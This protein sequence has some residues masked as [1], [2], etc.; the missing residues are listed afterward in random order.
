MATKA[1]NIISMVDSMPID[2]KTK[3][4]ETLLESL[5]STSKHIDDL[6]DAEAENRVNEIITGKVQTIPGEQV[7]KE[8]RQ[9][10]PK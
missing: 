1:S 8:I 4:V 10:F 2:M 5:H 9:K 3:L 6:W 7:F